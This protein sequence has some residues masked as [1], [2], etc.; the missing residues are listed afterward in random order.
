MTR[1]LPDSVWYK[2]FQNV[3][4]CLMNWLGFPWAAIISYEKERRCRNF[5]VQMKSPSNQKS[6]K[7]PSWMMLSDELY[8]KYI[9]TMDEK[10]CAGIYKSIATMKTLCLT[11]T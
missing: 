5:S 6:F 8:Q 9:G 4:T 11:S 10:L 7:N 3:S 2:F 1:Q